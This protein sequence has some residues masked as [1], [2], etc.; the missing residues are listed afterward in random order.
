MRD[1]AEAKKQKERADAAEK[2]L[3]GAQEEIR[4]L[5]DR[6]RYGLGDAPVEE[7]KPFVRPESGHVHESSYNDLDA[8]KTT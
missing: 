5:K 1:E 7:S 2:A 6:I 3:K 4:H 8:G